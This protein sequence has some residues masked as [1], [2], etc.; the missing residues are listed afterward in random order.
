MNKENF[1]LQF[2]IG[3]FTV[4]FGGSIF[5]VEDKDGKFLNRY[6]LILIVPPTSMQL[7]ASFEGKVFIPKVTVLKLLYFQMF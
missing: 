5:K 7:D 3:L 2:F 6:L 1:Y 4:N